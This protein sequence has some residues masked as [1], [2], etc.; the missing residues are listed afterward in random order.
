MPGAPANLAGAAIAKH[1]S[2]TLTEDEATSRFFINGKQF[3]MDRSVFSSPARTNTVE[4]W[5]IVNRTG[6]DHPF[7]LHNV[8]FQV[9][10]VNGIAQPYT[11]EQDTVPVPHEIDGRPGQVVIRVPFGQET[12]RFMFHCHIAA[13]EDKG[14][15]SFIDVVNPRNPHDD[16]TVADRSW[17][18]IC[19]TPAPYPG[20]RAA[21]AS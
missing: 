15:M 16:T 20:E 17:N 7:H 11:T 8:S 21:L 10:S 12:G 18:F 9:T 13:H 3:D 14:M 6:E 1:R 2:L 4:E 19:H 5:T